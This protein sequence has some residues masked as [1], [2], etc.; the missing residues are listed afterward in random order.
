MH[1]YTTHCADRQEESDCLIVL[2]SK[3]ENPPFNVAR[4]HGSDELACATRKTDGW[5]WRG[6]TIDDWQLYDDEIDDWQLYDDDI[7]SWQSRGTE[8]Y[9]VDASVAELGV[10]RMYLEI[11]TTESGRRFPV[12]QIEKERV[13]ANQ[14]VPQERTQQHMNE[15]NFITWNGIR[16][17]YSEEN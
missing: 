7:D 1:T 16:N 11:W 6:R 5:R 9:T 4:I 2:W 17:L 10:R 15:P 8:A 3:E 14:L 12:P 13:K